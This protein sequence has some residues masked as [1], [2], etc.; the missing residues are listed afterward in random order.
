[1]RGQVVSLVEEGREGRSGSVPL[2]GSAAAARGSTSPINA[3]QWK[4]R[5]V[6]EAL[7]RI[8][9]IDTCEVRDCLPSPDITVTGTR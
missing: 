2:P 7:S 5:I 4:K 6:L 3:T 1:M 8:A 9:R